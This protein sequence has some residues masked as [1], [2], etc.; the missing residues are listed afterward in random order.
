M[1]KSL[2]SLALKKFS[3]KT[4]TLQKLFLTLV[5]LCV[6]RLG[7]TIPL[8]TIDQEAFQKSLSQFQTQSSLFQLIN[9]YSGSIGAN[10]LTP[11]SLG[12]I[13]FIN[14]SIF[15]DLLTTLVPSLEKLQQEEG[16]FG[17]KKLKFYKKVLTLIFAIFQSLLLLSYLKPYFYDTSLISSLSTVSE[18]VTGALLIVWFTNIIDNYGVG[19]GTSILIFTNI[20]SSINYQSLFTGNLGKFSI[21]IGLLLFLSFL[22]CISQSARINVDV[23]SARQLSYLETLEKNKLRLANSQLGLLKDNGLTIRLTQAGIFPIILAANFLPLFSSG[24]NFFHIDSKLLS[25]TIYYVLII[26][27]NYFY[28]VLFWDPEKIS[29]QLRKA[30]V[31]IVNITPGK[32]TVTYLE[33]VVKSASLAGGVMLAFILLFYDILKQLLKSSFLNQLNISSLII[34]IGVAYELQKTI[35]SLPD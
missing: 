9:L 28:T 32:D 16:E 8:E 35:R 33:N 34:L 6:F 10:R 4:T 19:N 12:I 14:A 17:R 26:G 15:I 24:M 30:S 25:N 21:E 31:S 18:L 1:P 23:V 22:I 13:P 27:F 5:V 29:T 7:N 2:T 3:F 20:L 11:F